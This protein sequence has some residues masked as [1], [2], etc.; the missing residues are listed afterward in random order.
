MNDGRPARSLAMLE[1]RLASRC[2]S[3]ASRRSAIS[4]WRST[5]R[6]A[7]RPD[8]PQRRRQD[9]RLQPAHR[10]VQRRPRARSRSTAAP[11]TALDAAPDRRAAAS[12]RTFQNIRLFGELTRPRQRAGRLP[13]AR[14]ATTLRRRAARARRVASREERGDRGR[15]AASCSRSSTSTTAPTRRARN[16]PYGEPA[17]ARDRPRA[18]DRARS[19]CCSTSRPPA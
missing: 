14:A 18:G 11:S 10:R 6:A 15:S 2:A 12:A 13:P 7:V 8:R 4:T 3:A 16:L 9:H 17:P 19:C 1:P 5:P